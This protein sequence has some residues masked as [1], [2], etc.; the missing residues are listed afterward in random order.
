MA[1]P[2][3]RLSKPLEAAF[4]CLFKAVVSKHLKGNKRLYIK[5]SERN[6]ARIRDLKYLGNDQL[7]LF[8]EYLNDLDHHH[9]LFINWSPQREEDIEK[10][11]MSDCFVE[12]RPDSI[13]QIRQWFPELDQLYE[14]HSWSDRVLQSEFSGNKDVLAR[15]PLEI[16][17]YDSQE[18]ITRLSR[19]PELLQQN[20]MTTTELSAVLFDGHAKHLT[21]RDWLCRLFPEYEE[22]ILPRKIIMNVWLPD[23][24]DYVL[25]IENQDAFFKLVDLNPPC[26]LVFSAGYKGASQRLWEPSLC[27]FFFAGQLE[28]RNRFIS[29]WFEQC[30]TLYF[31]GDLDFAGL[32]ML[33]LMNQKYRA[34]VNA[35]QPGY[36]LLRDQ[37][38]A[39]KG[40]AADV[41][42]QIT[43]K[44]Q[45]R[46]ISATGDPWA[47][48]QLL[49]YLQ[50]HQSFVQ[51]ETVL[52][53]LNLSHFDKT[54]E[55]R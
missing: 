40:I 3:P 24:L 15:R 36:Q 30:M 5:F 29:S 54:G 8:F 28:Q 26:A 43:G 41:Y 31:W 35:W 21:H 13:E 47:D 4:F 49:Q 33:A 34:K 10:E 9:Q 14:R 38:E 12:F 45:N 17:G 51:Q 16:T 39:G 27:Q 19:I 1:L 20:A 7:G 11:D 32:D 53:L 48:E 23:D 37:I 42:Q 22:R 6:C 46:K 18:V 52:S 25:L 50:S 2:L 55:G 44:A